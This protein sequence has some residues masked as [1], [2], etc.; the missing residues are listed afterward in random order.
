MENT[1][2]AAGAAP[3]PQTE[4]TPNTNP[5]P[6][7][8][9]PDMHGFTS[10]ELADMRKFFDSQGG[11]TKV[12]SKISNPDKYVAEQKTVEQPQPHSIDEI[13]STR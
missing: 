6:A 7:P 11:Y 1:P 4:A 2:E 9:A 10:E 5:T 12:K 3:A 13:K 8:A